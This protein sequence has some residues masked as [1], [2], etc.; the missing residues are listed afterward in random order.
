VPFGQKQLCE[1]VE[2]GKRMNTIMNES[3]G[4]MIEIGGGQNLLENLVVRVS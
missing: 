2:M 3:S 1:V 4:A